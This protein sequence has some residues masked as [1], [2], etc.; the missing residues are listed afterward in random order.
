MISI[1]KAADK[2]AFI[3]VN[4]VLQFRNVSN[5]TDNGHVIDSV[6]SFKEEDYEGY[7]TLKINAY[8]FKQEDL[9]N[10]N[11]VSGVDWVG[12]LKGRWYGLDSSFPLNIKIT[13]SDSLTYNIVSSSEI[14]ETGDTSI[15]SISDWTDIS[16]P[17]QVTK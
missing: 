1:T 3:D 10:W 4:D 17:Y 15:T 2:F 11:Q 16:I 12:D 8:A 5:V 13:G 7:K 14:L 9:F 6:T